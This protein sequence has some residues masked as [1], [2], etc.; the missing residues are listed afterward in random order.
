MNSLSESQSKALLAQYGLPVPREQSA[1]TADE[2][3]VFAASLNGPVAVKAD[4]PGLAHKTE[5]GLVALGLTGDGAFRRAAG[6]ILARAPKGSRLLVQEMASG[7]RELILGM[8]RDPQWG[9]VISLGLGGIFAEALGDI[10]LRLA[11]V[12]DAEASA[13]IDDLG[14]TAIFGEYRGM[15]AVDRAAFAKAVMAVSRCAE[16][17]PDV[18]EIDVNPLIVTDAGGVVAVDALVVRSA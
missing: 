14:A 1:A 8:K 16:E 6:D 17:N 11:P 7:K 12:S 3:A 10:T 2:A 4:T 9:A 13:M 18:V 15:A 5:A